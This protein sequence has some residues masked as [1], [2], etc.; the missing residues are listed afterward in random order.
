MLYGKYCGITI[1]TV[2]WNMAMPTQQ[3]NL[4]IQQ[5][6]FRNTF[7]AI[8]FR[9]SRLVAQF[10]RYLY[11]QFLLKKELR[12]KI[13]ITVLI[14]FNSIDSP[15]HD[16]TVRTVYCPLLRHTLVCILTKIDFGVVIPYSSVPPTTHP[17]PPKVALSKANSRCHVLEERNAVLWW[18]R[19]VTLGKDSKS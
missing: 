6:S 7:I 17:R 9:L 15:Y 18:V 16:I 5:S 14:R 11:S 13:D 12:C 10:F 1:S 2:L 19:S 4:R 8:T 3:Q